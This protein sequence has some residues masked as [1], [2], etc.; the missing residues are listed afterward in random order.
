[1]ADKSLEERVSLVENELRGMP[2]RVTALDAEFQQF[3]V[4]V[5][6]EF[7][8]TREQLQKEIREGDEETRRLMRMLHEDLVARIALIDR[9]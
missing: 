2:E 4:E 7:S 5:R 8:A 6:D 3:R 9:G 1:M